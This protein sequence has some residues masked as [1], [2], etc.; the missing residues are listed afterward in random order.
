MQKE[1]LGSYINMMP[2][3]TGPNQPCS[4]EY[5]NFMQQAEMNPEYKL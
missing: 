4:T 2:Q 5:N 1:T 3:P